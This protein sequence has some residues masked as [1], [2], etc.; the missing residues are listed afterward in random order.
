M[1]HVM[2]Q[3]TNVNIIIEV[4]VKLL[5][6]LLLIL[7][8][9]GCRQQPWDLCK[10]VI[11][12]EWEKCDYDSGFCKPL[13]GNCS[14]DENCKEPFNYCDTT[15]HICK[16]TVCTDDSFCINEFNT[17]YCKDNHCIEYTD[18]DSSSDCD[19]LNY[20]N[21]N[22]F[23]YSKICTP[24]YN[25][26]FGE[27]IYKTLHKYGE[28]YYFTI[29]S[30]DLI[31][32][33]DIN[34]T[35][36]NIFYRADVKIKV[37]ENIYDIKEEVNVIT[38]C[39]FIE[40]EPETI[41][42]KINGISGNKKLY[43][44]I[45][46]SKTD[47]N[48]TCPDRNLEISFSQNNANG[49]NENI[50]C[51]A[52]NNIYY[53]KSLCNKETHLCY[54]NENQDVFQVGELCDKTINCIGDEYTYIKCLGYCYQYYC[55]SDSDCVPI[56]GIERKCINNDCYSPCYNNNEQSCLYYNEYCDLSSHYCST[57]RE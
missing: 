17:G 30:T 19:Y 47:C 54:A 37:F 51:V 18:C 44:Q 27:S 28:L 31:Y 22:F 56:N 3:Q 29:N 6:I 41:T 24:F 53:S 50:D 46:V 13:K 57:Y 2:N 45:F 38:G 33:F 25:V 15:T 21:R 12:D 1:K 9:F 36:L 10:D 42:C 8:F 52:L 14:M 32:D 34:I 5:P 35:G 39:D 40:H 7:L 16:E 48:S 26:N 11:C 55:D 23:C 43:I 49:C 4:K 20:D